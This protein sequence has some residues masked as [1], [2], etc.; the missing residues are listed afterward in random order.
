M[1]R[2]A[3]ATTLWE[4]AFQAPNSSGWHGGTAMGN[5]TITTLGAGS[6]ITSGCALRTR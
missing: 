3:P 1:I 6:S 4:K 5:Y 2:S